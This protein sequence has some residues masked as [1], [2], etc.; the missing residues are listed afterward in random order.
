MLKIFCV[1]A[2]AFLLVFLKIPIIIKISDRFHFFDKADKHRKRKERNISRLGGFGIFS[3]FLITAFTFL[4]TADNEMKVLIATIVVLAMIGLK[5]DVFGGLSA[6]WKFMV[7]IAVALLLVYF[8]DYRIT[9]LHGLFYIQELNTLSSALISTLLIVFII[10]SFNLIDGIDGLAATIG[11]IASVLF[12]LIFFISKADQYAFP[13]FLLAGLTAGFLIYNYSPAKVFMG[14]TGSTIIGIII[15][16]MTINFANLHKTSKVIVFRPDTSVVIAL[17][18]LIIPTF[19]TLRIFVI[20]LT[21]GKSPFKGDM[22]HIHHR[23]SSLGMSDGRVVIILAS[24]NV[25]TVAISFYMLYLTAQKL[26]FLVF[27]L[28]VTLNGLLTLIIYIKKKSAAK[29]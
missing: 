17:A 19:D 12:G 18:I 26:L 29:F 1:F 24:I 3:G 2:F 20:R 7:H 4:N 10:N 11:F 25:C 8:G 28:G 9:S 23:L 5:D 14:D 13:A 15:A 27:G 21:Q 16:T 6:N 22:N